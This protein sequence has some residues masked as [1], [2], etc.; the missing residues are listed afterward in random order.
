MRADKVALEEDASNFKHV[1]CCQVI[2][3]YENVLQD[4]VFLS[5]I[6]HYLLENWKKK[7]NNTFSFIKNI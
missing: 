7:F 4:T 3:L 5:I 6:K 2:M 1:T